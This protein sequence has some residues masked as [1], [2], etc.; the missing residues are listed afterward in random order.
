LRKSKITIREVARAADVSF[1]TVSRVLS[2]N[3]YASDETRRK[4]ERAARK[5]GYVPNRIASGLARG[6]TMSIGMVIPDIASVH[7]AEMALGA[8]SAATKAGYHL[9]L[10]NTTGSLEQE[11]HILHF[12]HQTRVDG[13]IMAGAR[14]PDR[15][16]RLA[17]EQFPAFVSIN[18]PIVSQH[19]E[20]IISEHAK[21]IAMSV[22]HVTR[23][24]RRK[25]AFM[26]GPR[27]SYT[28]KERLRGFRQAMKKFNL[29]I[30]RDL[31][32]PYEANYGDGFHSQWEWFNATDVGSAQWNDRRAMLGER[33]ACALLTA[34]PEV[35][36]I[37]CF[38]DQT[39]FGALRACAKL[40]RRVPCDIAIIGCNDIPLASQVTPTLTTQRIP[41]YQS[42]T[43]AVE[44]LI[45]RI[46][47]SPHQKP[48]VFPHELILR[49]SAPAIS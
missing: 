31:I 39:A 36:A 38:D 9:I 26:A 11:K 5:L 34:H 6:R 18:H 42:G 20:N 40:G 3:G 49:E 45:Q 19:G 23:S 43:C 46:N 32:V 7:F 29:P 48:V 21:G 8:E 24:H 44:L 15:D 22:Q 30:D 16:L 4:V 35:D 28:A 12:L 33:G 27:N 17:L 37:I 13:V 14:L 2:G 41:R 25:I 1:K 47:G 10:A